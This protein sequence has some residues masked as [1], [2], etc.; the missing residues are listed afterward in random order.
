MGKRAKKAPV[1]TKKRQTLAKQFKC[2]FCTNDEVVECKMDLKNNTGS[3]SCRMCSASYSMPIHHLHE[4]ID[5]FS[6]WLDDC[7]AAERG[8]VAPA[9]SNRNR[10]GGNNNNLRNVVHD[11]S[12][13]HY[14]DDDSV[15]SEGLPEASGLSGGGNKKR[16][17]ASGEDGGGGKKPKATTATLGLD[18]SDDESD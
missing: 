5:V 15:E 4:P 14:D 11:T 3:L 2:P 16:P 12:Q 6:E 7:E 8:E 9:A 17:A 18:E 1:Q 10:K 13:D